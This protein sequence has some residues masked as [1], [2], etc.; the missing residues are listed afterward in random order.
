MNG[1]GHEQKIDPDSQEN[2]IRASTVAYRNR[3]RRVR[4]PEPEEAQAGPSN[5]NGE[6]PENEEAAAA[7]SSGQNAVSAAISPFM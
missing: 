6:A 2:N 4:T 1:G 5:T 3:A 7:G